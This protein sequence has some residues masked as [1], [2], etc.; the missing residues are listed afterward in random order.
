MIILMMKIDLMD[1]LIITLILLLILLFVCIVL[2]H[3]ELKENFKCHSKT[4]RTNKRR[5]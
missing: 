4:N 3:Y 5:K 1:T 2:I